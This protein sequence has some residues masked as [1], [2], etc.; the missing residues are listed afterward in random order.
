MAR[1]QKKAGKRREAEKGVRLRGGPRQRE[2]WK[3]PP[4][5]RGRIAMGAEWG[6]DPISSR[7]E[8]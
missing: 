4:R 3:I 7:L 8:S 6:D 5:S 2:R 1:S